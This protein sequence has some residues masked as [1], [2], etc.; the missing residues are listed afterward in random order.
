MELGNVSHET[1]TIG[2]KGLGRKRLEREPESLVDISSYDLSVMRKIAKKEMNKAVDTMQLDQAEK[3]YK[4]T[5]IELFLRLKGD[6]Y[7]QEYDRWEQMKEQKEIL[8]QK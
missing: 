3:T 6:N 1:V 2:E 8:W 5:T 7:R 4:Q